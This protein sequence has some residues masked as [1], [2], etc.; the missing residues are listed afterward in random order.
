MKSYVYTFLAHLQRLYVV[1]N[2]FTLVD[3]T[4]V[5]VLSQE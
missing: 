1:L 3:N 5:L 4:K 2:V